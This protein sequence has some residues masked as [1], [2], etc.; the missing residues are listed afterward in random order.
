MGRE[1]LDLQSAISAK[2]SEITTGTV[3]GMADKAQT[4]VR[5]ANGQTRLCFGD[6]PLG[7]PVIVRGD[8]I[9]AQGSLGK[10]YKFQLKD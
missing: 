1:L 2:G 4:R 10:K 8:Q 6:A 9:I 3:I 5:L 7:T